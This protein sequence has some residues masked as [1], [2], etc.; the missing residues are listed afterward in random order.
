MEIFVFLSISRVGITLATLRP[1][2]PSTFEPELSM[3][4][5]RTF[6]T[7]ALG[8]MLAVG[9]LPIAAQATPVYDT[10]VSIADLTG[11]RST[12]G[13]GL[14]DGTSAT[15]SLS[16]VIT[17]TLT[18]YHYAYTFHSGSQQGVSHVILDL[19]DNCTAV[20]TCFQNVV[21]TGG[22][23]S[24]PVFG[25]YTSANG[26]P[27]MPGTIVG[28]KVSI[29]DGSPN[30]TISFDSNRKPV[31][32]DFYTKGGNGSS[33]GFS[34]YNVG[35]GHEGTDGSI[36]DFVA[37]PDTI[38]VSVDVPRVAEPASLA[39]LGAGLLGLA[40]ARRRRAA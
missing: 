37:L 8:A 23:A 18:G 22:S 36:A 40:A 19:S 9:A 29:G 25:T 16:W 2:T 21:V 39:L 11:S 14:L 30:Y 13:N 24:S 12:G 34:I 10:S 35:L 15:A 4:L 27:N 7:F 38:S 33:N 20:G 1:R 28:V 31:W 5:S 32:E 3:F 26:N 6:R 17:R